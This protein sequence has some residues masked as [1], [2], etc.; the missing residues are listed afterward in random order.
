MWGLKKRKIS[1]MG[2][3]WQRPMN[4][5]DPAEAHDQAVFWLFCFFTHVPARERASRGESKEERSNFSRHWILEPGRYVY[6]RNDGGSIES[7][8]TSTDFYW[9]LLYPC[10]VAIIVFTTSLSSMT[11]VSIKL[12]LIAIYRFHAIFFLWQHSHFS[13]FKNRKGDDGRFSEIH[14]YFF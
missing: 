9:L 6:W 12:Y 4:N 11:M 13:R 8:G 5:N 3:K 1:A 14:F 2:A 7:A 10:V